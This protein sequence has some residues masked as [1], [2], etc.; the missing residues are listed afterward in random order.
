M[1]C[2]TSGACVQD[3]W[4]SLKSAVMGNKDTRRVALKEEWKVKIR[5]IAEAAEQH[6]QMGSAAPGPAEPQV[7]A[8]NLGLGGPASNQA[9]HQARA[10]PLIG[11]R[12]IPGGRCRMAS[13]LGLDDL[14]E[15]WRLCPTAAPMRTPACQRLGGTGA[16]TQAVAPRRMRWAAASWFRSTSR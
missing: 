2:N 4:R 14:I 8:H 13:R 11:A 16:L 15:C 9:P 7:D 3:K 5:Q 12:G 6:R 1:Q 10:R